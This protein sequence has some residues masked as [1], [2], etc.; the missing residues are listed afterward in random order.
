MAAR[1]LALSALTSADPCRGIEYEAFEQ[2][3]RRTLP[4]LAVNAPARRAI[5]RSLS[6][7][8][9]CVVNAVAPPVGLEEGRMF[10]T[11]ANRESST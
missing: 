2:A 6:D 4:I 10:L 11:G 5:P 7:G 8:H 3:S 9:S 1:D